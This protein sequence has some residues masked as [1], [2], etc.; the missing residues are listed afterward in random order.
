MRNQQEIEQALAEL[1]R[2]S[3]GFES[4]GDNRITQDVLRWVLGDPSVAERAIFA[5]PRCEQPRGS[6][7]FE[8]SA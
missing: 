4:K 5:V 1:E 7:L 8:A 2:R 6:L 3:L